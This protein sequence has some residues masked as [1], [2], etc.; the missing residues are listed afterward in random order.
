[1]RY[2]LL[3]LIAV[4]SLTS[5]EELLNNNSSDYQETVNTNSNKGADMPARKNF[6]EK[7]LEYQG[8]SINLTRH[9]RCRME[10]RKLDA[11]EVQEVINQGKINQRKSN[12][13]SKP[14]PSLA[15]EGKTSD[16]QT[17]RIVLGTCEGNYKIITAIDL[18]NEWKCDCK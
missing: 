17:A 9:G 12:P 7:D 3:I 14:C 13:N 8:Q 5:C 2:I 15:F 6:S 4:F 16:G 18:K 10:C 11:F 1:M